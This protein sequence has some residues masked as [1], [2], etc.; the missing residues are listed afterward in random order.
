MFYKKRLAVFATVIITLSIGCDDNPVTSST[1][2]FAKSIIS[3]NIA[4]DYSEGNT[5]VY[6]IE[7]SNIYENVLSIH[8]DNSIRTY[9]GAVYIIERGD[10]SNII[11]ITGS[12]IS[13][14]N[15]DKQENIG[16]ATNIQD[17]AFINASKAYVTQYDANTIVI[18]NPT[19][20]KKTT[21][22]INLAD[23][24]ADGAGTPKMSSALYYNSKVYVALQ[25]LD[26]SYAITDNSSLAVI[27]ADED[28]VIKEIVLD[29][30]NPQGMYIYD[31]KMYIACTNAYGTQ[32]GGIEVVNLL[33]DET[34]GV[35]MNETELA[36]DVANVIIISD[37]QGY[38]I[39]TG[40]DWS[41]SVVPFNPASG[42]VGTALA[43]VDN[44][45]ACGLAYDGTN[46]YV[47]DRS[48][49]NPGLLVIDP[50]DN[51][52]ASGPH[53]LGMPPNAIALLEVEE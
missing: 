2:N 16:N 45:A 41:N 10:F 31:S 25:K 49:T 40:A 38:A 24:S 29:A 4:A 46:L 19:T 7:S 12:S 42:S 13:A 3:V 44:A 39:V 26:D 1:P 9:N 8:S 37:T 36:G 6:D 11:K 5:S 22:T 47:G 48:S 35:L 18:Y 32:D 23:Y 33:T 34:E 27:D 53:D 50:S 28:T 51:S 20:G 15:V 52:I 17:I 43:D 21:D 30:K 14:D